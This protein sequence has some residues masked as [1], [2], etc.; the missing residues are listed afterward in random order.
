M[1]KK[2]KK[3]TVKTKRYSKEER[4]IFLKKIGETNAA[5]LRENSTPQEKILYKYLKELGYKFE[6]QVPIV[7][8]TMKVPKL[9]ILDFLLTTYNIFIECDGR[10]HNS[11]EGLKSDNLRSK[12]LAT[13]GY[14][15]LRFTNRQI[16][17]YT[18][19]QIKQ[20]ID[21]KIEMLKSRHSLDIK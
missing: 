7:I 8:S 2:V 16:T 1:A 11:K 15:P 21:H 18:R 17:T 5:G 14:I 9:Y 19:N 13:L 3:K 20:I 6:F 4:I 12:R 10:Q